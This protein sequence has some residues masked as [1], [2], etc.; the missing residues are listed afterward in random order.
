M[1]SAGNKLIKNHPKQNPVIDLLLIAIAVKEMSKIRVIKDRSKSLEN[2]SC[3][4][5]RSGGEVL[6]DRFPEN[7]SSVILAGGVGIK[8]KVKY[9]T[10]P[11]ISRAILLLM[12]SNNAPRVVIWSRGIRMKR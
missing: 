2:I 11:W 9:I 12:R 5:F 10:I 6:K 1:H 8:E 4:F 3:E 7:A